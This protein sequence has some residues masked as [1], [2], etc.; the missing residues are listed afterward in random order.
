MTNY[1]EN[2]A[3]MN[4]NRVSNSSSTSSSN[5]ILAPRPNRKNPGISSA[6]SVQ[7]NSMSSYRSASGSPRS[8]IASSSA[9]RYTSG[10]TA[11]STFS[12]IDEYD[13]TS[14]SNSSAIGFLNESIASGDDFGIIDTLDY[15]D[16]DDGIIGNVNGHKQKDRRLQRR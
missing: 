16:I 4:P 12:S 11:T 3:T 5:N 1:Y 8:S 13:Q 7:T 15:E 9:S 6:S 14:T 2:T 10:L